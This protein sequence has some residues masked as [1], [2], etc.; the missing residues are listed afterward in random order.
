MLQLKGAYFLKDE[1]LF[2]AAQVEVL[3]TDSI[4]IYEVLRVVDSVCLFV[5]EHF[6]R[7]RRSAEISGIFLTMNSEEFKKRIYQLIEAN[8][9][10]EGNIK[11]LIQIGNRK[12]SSFFYFIQ[13]AYPSDNMYWEGVTTEI[14]QAERILPQA[15]T[16]QKNLRNTADRMIERKK[17]YDV[18]L[19]DSEGRITEGSKTN[20]FFVDSN[21]I[22]TS[23]QELVLPG[24]TRQKVMECIAGAGL[25]CSEVDLAATSVAQFEAAFFTGTSPKVLPIAKIGDHCF[26]AD[27]PSVLLLMEAYDQMVNRYIEDIKTKGL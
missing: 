13:H 16:F 10:S 15:K 9:F 11:V 6:E 1:Y 27:H 5:S 2:S 23:K 3:A 7:L 20:I 25:S 18:V 17:L 21:G 4:V 19:V 14:L 24:I 26:Q 12:Q 8:G 22:Y